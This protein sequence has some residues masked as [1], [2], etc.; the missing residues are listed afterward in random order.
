MITRPRARRHAW[1]CA[2]VRLHQAGFSSAA[3]QQLHQHMVGLGDDEAVSAFINALADRVVHDDVDSSSTRIVFVIGSSGS[4]R[5]R[6]ATKIAAYFKEHGISER[7][8]LAAAAGPGISASE[9]I[10]TY[11][12][13]LNMRAMQIGVGEVST[14]IQETSNRMIIDLNASPK[15]RARHQRG[16][17]TARRR[18]VTVVQA[19]PADAAPQ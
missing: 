17:G 8:M 6:S 14:V 4:A 19:I 5:R 7:M 2:P 15:M 16:G 13:L 10:K 18:K 12:R 11:A 9:D 3:I 1:S